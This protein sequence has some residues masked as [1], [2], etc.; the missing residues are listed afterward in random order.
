[1]AIDIRG[2]PIDR[3]LRAHVAGRLASALGRLVTK[4]I[5]TQVTFFDENGPRGGP[6]MRCAMTVRLPHRPHARVE[7][8]AE[9]PRLAFDGALAKLERELEQARDR[10]L[11]SKRHPKKY[12]TAKRLLEPQAP[13]PRARPARSPGGRGLGRRGA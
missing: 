8:T 13:A 2:I 7:D 10:D 9:T 5:T 6:A 11:D 12:Y 4:P 3:G 1:M